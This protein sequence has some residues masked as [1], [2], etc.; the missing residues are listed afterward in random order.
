MTCPECREDHKFLLLIIGL[1]AALCIMV[2]AVSGRYLQSR[3]NHL[4]KT[5]TV[6]RWHPKVEDDYP[7]CWQEYNASQP[8]GIEVICGP[9]SL[10]DPKITVPGSITH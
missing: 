5:G 7:A 10:M 4:P 1:V 6:Q 2:S 9:V 8:G 3:I